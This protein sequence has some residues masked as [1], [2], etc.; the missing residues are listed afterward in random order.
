MA[1]MCMLSC[2]ALS[3]Q[4]DEQTI[5][6]SDP[7][8]IYTYVGGGPK[9]TD[10]TNGASMWEARVIGNVGMG[11][12]DMMLFETGYGRLDGSDTRKS[13]SGF[14]DS[15]IRWFHLFE[16]D[17]EKLGY[18]GLS[19]QV[20]AQL[21]GD[22]PGTDG[23]NVINIGAMPAWSFTNSL[24]IYFSLNVVNSWDK[25]FD[26]YNGAGAGFDAQLIYNADWWPG[27]QLRL[28]PAYSY[29]LTGELDGE[30]S[31]SIQINTGGEFTPTLMWDVTV[32]KQFDKDLNAFRRG[33]DTGFES[34]WD[35]FFN[36]TSYF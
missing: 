11:E 20:D 27:A 23:Q 9:Y 16:M 26:K 24:S 6:A 28:I 1:F 21:A 12:H 3:V 4:A 18:R 29:F 25:G 2:I 14:S 5:D 13:E 15:R 35:V 7:T 33:E 17:Y 31:G 36:V 30:G 19:T 10:Y 32:S 22:L 8:R 34:D